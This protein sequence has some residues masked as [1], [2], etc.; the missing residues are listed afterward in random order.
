ME[1]DMIDVSD[2]AIIA[3]NPSNVSAIRAAFVIFKPCFSDS[4]K[5]ELFGEPIRVPSALA[6]HFKTVVTMSNTF[7]DQT[8]DT[9][10][11]PLNDSFELDRPVLEKILS[12]V[13][14]DTG[15]MSDEKRKAEIKSWLVTMSDASLTPVVNQAS[16]LGY[17]RLLDVIA[18]H[19]ADI[20]VN[21]D[22][23]ELYAR[24]NVAKPT[25]EQLQKI[26]QEN[27]HIVRACREEVQAENDKQ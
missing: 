13:S 4:S 25:N 27:I 22:E 3:A 10:E 15:N 17:A 1:H 12:F 2:A 21:T 9:F 6:N 16:L 26:L 19:F 11:F 14:L 8:S 23:D 18:D 24:F 20:I 7:E 5:N